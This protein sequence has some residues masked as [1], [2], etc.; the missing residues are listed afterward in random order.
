MVPEKARSDG[1]VIDVAFLDDLPGVE[2]GERKEKSRPAVMLAQED[3][4][5]SDSP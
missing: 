2:A 3:R 5:S 4:G 1:I